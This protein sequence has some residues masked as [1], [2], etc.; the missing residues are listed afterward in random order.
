MGGS[1][2]GSNFDSG[3]LVSSPVG[4]GFTGTLFIC[5]FGF[6]GVGGC[7]SGSLST[8]ALLLFRLG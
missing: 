3:F 8:L 5:V 6:G 7:T 2:F 1:G 4:S